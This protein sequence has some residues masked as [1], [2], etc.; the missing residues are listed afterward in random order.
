M[1]TAARLSS[2]AEPLTTTPLRASQAM[3][4][5]TAVGVARINGHGQATTSTASAGRKPLR[6]SPVLHRQAISVTKAAPS[7]KGRKIAGQPIGR[8]FQRGFLPRGLGNQ[9]D[10]FGQRRCLADFVRD[11]AE[12]SVLIERSREDFAARCL[13]TGRLSPVRRALIDGRGSGRDCA[14][15]GHAFAGPNRHRFAFAELADWD[16]DFATA[17]QHVGHV[18][19]EIENAANRRLGP[20]ERVAFDALAA[21]CD[22]DDESRGRILAED[23]GREGR[24]RKGQLG[25]DPAFKE[26]FE[27]LIKNASAA[28]HGRQECQSKA[29][30]RLVSGPGRIAEQP[31]QQVGR[32]QRTDDDRQEIDRGRLVMKAATRQSGTRPGRRVVGQK[33]AGRIGNVVHENVSWRG[34]VRRAG[35]QDRRKEKRRSCGGL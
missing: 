25:S 29:E 4:A 22:E 23:D 2:A 26:A 20:I 27:R 10:D 13:S 24:D 6:Q 35:L 18:G 17:A 31:D 14:V 34:E 21:Q 19:A 8:A 33:V 32:Q 30:R 9:L 1:S 28:E 11:D 3:A 5:I 16:I 12:R 15:D 7:T